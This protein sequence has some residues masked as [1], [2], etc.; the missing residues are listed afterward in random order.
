MSGTIKKNFKIILVFLPLML[1]AILIFLVATII[2]IYKINPDYGFILSQK[3]RS[4]AYTLQ[5][6]VYNERF[7]LNKN[8]GEFSY[9]FF[10]DE[11]KTKKVRLTLGEQL[12]RGSVYA[13]GNLY[14][15]AI[16]PKTLNLEI[17]SGPA[18]WHWHW[19]NWLGI[20]LDKVCQQTLEEMVNSPLPVE[21]NISTSIVEYKNNQYGFAFS[22]PSSWIGYTIID[23][24]WTGY[25]TGN[26]GDEKFTEGPLLSI[27]HPLWT[28][29]TPRQDIPVMIFT[30]SQWQD[31]Q[32]DKFHIGAA[33][34]GPSELGHNAKYV[35]S[36]PARY[37][38]AFPVGYE[39]VDEIIRN[40]P[41]RTF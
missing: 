36:L 12:I 39:E 25:A 17:D 18:T 24:V 33:P 10:G 14:A 11:L 16:N 13:G 9:R 26:G 41:L 19:Y 4:H 28:A 23:E 31:L 21:N 1:L 32:D 20:G 8:F 2:F 15:G 3:M 7:N 27:R 37:N 38:F 34:I 22:L 40:N 35:F 6:K 30:V 29:K 5:E